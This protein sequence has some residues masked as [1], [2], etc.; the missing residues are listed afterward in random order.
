MS[1]IRGHFPGLVALLPGALAFSAHAQSTTPSAGDDQTRCKTGDLASCVRSETTRCDMGEAKACVDLSRR[2]FGGVAVSRDTTRGRQLYERA[3]HLADSSCTTGDLSGCAIAGIAYGNGRGAP[4]DLDRA[5]TLEERACAGGNA[6]GCFNLGFASLFGAIGIARDSIRAAQLLEPACAGG[7]AN[8]CFQLGWNYEFGR[9]VARDYKRAAAFYQEA[10]DASYANDYMMGCHFLGSAYAEGRGVKEDAAH[11]AQLYDRACQGGNGSGC[12]N[13]GQLY[14]VGRAVGKDASRAAQL[15]DRTCQL[16]N[17]SGCD[18]LSLLYESGNGVGRDADRAKKLHQQACDLGFRPGCKISSE[19]T[20]GATLGGATS[21]SPT[22][23]AVPSL[24]GTWEAKQIGTTLLFSAEGTVTVVVGVMLDGKYRLDGNQLRA[25]A[26]GAVLPSVQMVAFV[27]DTAL[28]TGGTNY[29]KLI[30]FGERARP[31]SLVGQWRW[32]DSAGVTGYEEYTVEGSWRLRAAV[33]HTG[34]VSKG[35]YSVRGNTITMRFLSPQIEERSE[36]F[37]LRGNT[38]TIRGRN[39][40]A[41]SLVR[42]RPLLP[43]DVE[44]PGLPIR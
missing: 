18:N 26:P 39:G 11:A 16:G 1:T 17:P 8:A 4:R 2:Y 40:K 35:F 29:R 20:P 22:A 19:T 25:E 37:T 14:Q 7:H 38:L 36:P 23:Q 13:L 12:N 15:Y 21:L 33:P 3:F 30:P 31:N 9:T 43:T 6:D 32:I 27:G 24:V 5:K 34:S 10:C 44:Q 28:I 42:A 41:E